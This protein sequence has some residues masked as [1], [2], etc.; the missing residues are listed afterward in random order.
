M[1][2]WKIGF[3]GLAGIIAA[4]VAYLSIL[5]GKQAN[6]SPIPKAEV[7]FKLQII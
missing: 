1:N 2:R 7:E 6:Q 5:I 3:F 4:A